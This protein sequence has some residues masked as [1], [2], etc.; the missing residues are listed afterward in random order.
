MPL[1]SFTDYDIRSRI[2]FP[3]KI[4]ISELEDL[5]S[6]A[7]VEHL[8]TFTFNEETQI[9]I[10]GDYG[11]IKGTVG[12]DK[13]TN[14]SGTINDSQINSTEFRFVK[15]IEN[16]QTF[17]GIKFSS[18]GRQYEEIKDGEIKIWYNMRDITKKY[19]DAKKI[20]FDT[21]L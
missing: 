20:T 19:F 3:E 14:I 18:F 15:R 6:V 11:G 17:D 4:G 13:Y 9:K 12:K 1:T 21:L 10:V 5:L 7:A 16:N 8:Y 2:I